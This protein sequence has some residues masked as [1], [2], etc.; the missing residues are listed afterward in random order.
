MDI[1][2]TWSARGGQA[3]DLLK[4][5]H[6]V[7][8]LRGVPEQDLERDL[9][10]CR[11]VL[12]PGHPEKTRRKRFEL[13]VNEM[14]RQHR[15]VKELMIDAPHPGLAR[16]GMRGP[17]RA[18]VRIEQRLDPQVEPQ[19]KALAEDPTRRD[20]GVLHRGT[21]VVHVDDTDAEVYHLPDLRARPAALFAQAQE[22]E[23]KELPEDVAAFDEEVHGSV[24]PPA[25][26]QVFRTG[27]FEHLKTTQQCIAGIALPTAPGQCGSALQELHCPL[28]PGSVA[29]HCRSCTAHCPLPTGSAVDS[30]RS[31]TASAHRQNGDSVHEVA[32]PYPPPPYLPPPYPP[33]TTPYYPP[34]PP[35]PPPT[36]PPYLPPLPPPPYLPPLPSARFARRGG[37]TPHPP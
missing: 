9:P 20:F 32:P 29:V 14:P 22:A 18:L 12:R 34:P 1:D 13:T 15:L 24:Q 28:P 16:G 21:P 35:Y 3:S 19:V 8:R 30:C 11:Q 27:A 10:Q 6:T 33:P 26:V 36:S 5:C 25:A 17:V 31:S 2:V 37:Q 23:P 4:A 7:R